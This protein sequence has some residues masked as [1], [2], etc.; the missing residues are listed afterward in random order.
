MA[1]VKYLLALLSHPAIP[2]QVCLA[3]QVKPA[4][5]PLA[6]RVGSRQEP[7]GCLLFVLPRAWAEEYSSGSRF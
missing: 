6:Q 7:A 2:A 5:C 4:P 1:E 3:G